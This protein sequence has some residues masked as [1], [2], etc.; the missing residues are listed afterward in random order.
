MFQ[1]KCCKK[2]KTTFFMKIVYLCFQKKI[3]FNLKRIL[4]KIFCFIFK[5]KKYLIFC[6]LFY[7]GKINCSNEELK[8]KEANLLNLEKKLSEAE[9]KRTDFF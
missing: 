1:K 3:Q 5:N 7:F 8:R 4:H 6:L 2:Y 9:Q